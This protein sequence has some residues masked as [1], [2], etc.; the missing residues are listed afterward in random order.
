VNWGYPM[1]DKFRT[2][3]QTCTRGLSYAGM[4]FIFPM[5]LLTTVDATGRDLLSR[6]VRGAFEVSSLVLSVFILLGLAYAQ[7]M[8]DHVRVTMLID[9][10]PVR[11]S[12][13]INMLTTLLCMFIVAVMAWQGVAVAYESSSVTDMLRIPQFPFRLL[14]TLAGVLLF[15]EFLCD[16][17]DE[18]RRFIA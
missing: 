1:F 2:I 9:R 11:L 6:P 12:C 5:M 4:A 17:I 7:Q 18:G 3:V 16:L 15:L 13:A 14:V 8:K 10:L